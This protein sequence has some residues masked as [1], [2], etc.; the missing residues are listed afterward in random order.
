MTYDMK[1]DASGYAF[2]KTQEER[3]RLRDHDCVKGYGGR[4]TS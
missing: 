3:L 1:I 4:I 2:K